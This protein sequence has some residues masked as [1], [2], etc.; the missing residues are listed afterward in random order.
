MRR[1][2]WPLKIR[3]LIVNSQGEKVD[4]RPSKNREVRGKRDLELWNRERT[5]VREYGSLKCVAKRCW[6]KVNWFGGVIWTKIRRR[7]SSGYIITNVVTNVRFVLRISPNYAPISPN[8]NDIK[9]CRSGQWVQRWAKTPYLR[10][11]FIRAECVSFSCVAWQCALPLLAVNERWVGSKTFLAATSLV[12][13][14][15]AVAWYMRVHNWDRALLRVRTREPTQRQRLA[16]GA[17]HFPLEINQ[18]QSIGR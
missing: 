7:R 11:K 5:L 4:C 10:E 2:V 3:Y 14:L 16:N 13:W 12:E 15:W 1:R 17:L 9:A 8:Q 18:L 6:D